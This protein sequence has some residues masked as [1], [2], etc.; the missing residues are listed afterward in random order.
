MNGGTPVDRANGVRARIL[1]ASKRDWIRGLIFSYARPEAG[2][3]SGTP[4]DLDS[5]IAQ[6]NMT[7]ATRE[8]ILRYVYL[9]LA[10][11]FAVS[12]AL[13]IAMKGALPFNTSVSYSDLS[14]VLTRA[15]AEPAIGK[16]IARAGAHEGQVE[17][18]SV[19]ESYREGGELYYRATPVS[20]GANPEVLQARNAQ[21]V[22]LL[23]LPLLGVWVR[24]LNHPLGALALL[25][26]PLLAF[27]LNLLA[28]MM[29]SNTLRSLRTLFAQLEARREERARARRAVREEQEEEE[30]G[31]YVS[32]PDGAVTMYEN[33]DERQAPEQ[34]GMT[35]HLRPRR[36]SM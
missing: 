30:T 22:V 20:G 11:V 15:H 5:C 31:D 12:L 36:Y 18:Y 28:N 29:G 35:V 14:L 2:T 1:F 17:L 10:C 26:I 9:A 33:R 21:H 16:S 7:Y 24:M 19:L 27:A 8:S 23:S 13:L 3:L 34:F 32:V 6:Y 4:S 25:G